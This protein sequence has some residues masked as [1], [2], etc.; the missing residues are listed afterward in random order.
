MHNTMNRIEKI[1]GRENQ[2][3]ELAIGQLTEKCAVFEKKYHLSSDR[4]YDLWQ[5]GKMADEVD[6]FEWKALID[7]IREWE[8]TQEELKKLAAA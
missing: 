4:F 1:I 7:G 5:Q 2:I 8:Q 6:F 3:C